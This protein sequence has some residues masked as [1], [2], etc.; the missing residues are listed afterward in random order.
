MHLRDGYELGVLQH[1]G[2]GLL[3]EVLRSPPAVG[4]PETG[5]SVV[6]SLQDEA[7]LSASG[8]GSLERV[9]AFHHHYDATYFLGSAVH[10]Y[11]QGQVNHPKKV[12][13]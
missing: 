13:Q 3:E 12:L 9:E 5:F 1:R 10:R 8:G 11:E 2:Q 6:G 4:V 7:G